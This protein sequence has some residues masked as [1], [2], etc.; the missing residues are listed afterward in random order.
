[1]LDYE[2][3]ITNIPDYPKKGIIFKDITTL[4]LDAE[5]FASAI[6]DIAEHFKDKGI[7]KV[8]GTEARGFVIGA[9]LA[10]ELGAGF[11]TVRKPGK[12]PRDVYSEEYELEYGTD[13]IEMHKDAI[14]PGDVVLIADDLIATG[15]TAV[16]SAKLVQKAGG[17]VG[18]YA[19]LLELT[20]FNARAKLAEV[21][22]EDFFALIE[23][24]E[25]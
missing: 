1:M 19:F 15:G 12:L 20:P 21:A 2:S 4:L 11:V 7:T 23:V 10:I 13:T 18:G 22:D 6:H 17:K 5:G 16:A 25:Y 24:D 8:A 3:L 9:P 14:Q